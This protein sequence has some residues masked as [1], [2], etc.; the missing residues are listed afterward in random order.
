MLPGSILLV[1]FGAAKKGLEIQGDDDEAM[2]GN[3]V[4]LCPSKK[5]GLQEADMLNLW[6]RHGLPGQGKESK[7]APKFTICGRAQWVAAHPR[8]VDKVACPMRDELFRGQ[9]GI[10]R[11]ANDKLPKALHRMVPS[12]LPTPWFWHAG[13][14]KKQHTSDHPAGA[15]AR[16]TGVCCKRAHHT[17]AGGNSDRAGDNSV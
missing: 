2:K 6:D 11:G 10:L 7:L 15:A 16:S 1:S 14:R 4:A 12:R 5:A 9:M 8:M 3:K 13:H 17:K